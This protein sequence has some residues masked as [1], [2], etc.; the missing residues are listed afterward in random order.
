MKQNDP[1]VSEGE[2]EQ[3]AFLEFFRALA[4]SG[5]LRVAAAIVDEARDVSAVAAVT[6]LATRL[7]AKHLA[8]L[9]AAGFALE[10]RE[11]EMTRYQWDEARVRTLAATLGSPRMRALAGASDERSRLLA[12]FF[13]D[14]QLVRLPVGAARQKVIAEEIVERFEYDR[15]YG[16]R[17]LN[18][19]LKEIVEDYATVR[20]LM[21]DL[22]L[23]N[24][25]D[26]VYWRGQGGRGAEPPNVV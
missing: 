3:P 16:E 10:L 22:H 21:V 20:R 14:G 8:T 25:Q 17:E 6:G 4:D 5:R 18:A 13:R 12:S 23:M 7:V 11:G 26:G 1:A 9:V 19:I 24:R 2:R 15:V